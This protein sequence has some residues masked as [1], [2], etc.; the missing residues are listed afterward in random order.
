MNFILDTDHLSIVQQRRGPAFIR[1]SIRLAKVDRTEIGV[2]IISFQEQMKGWL[3]LLNRARASAQIVM[4]FGELARMA[5]SFCKMNV[6]SYTDSA[7]DQF[8][9]LRR[10]R[11]R[12][13]TTDL[14]LACVC[15]VTGATLLTRNI[16]DFRQ[17]PGLQVEDWTI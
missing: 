14:R 11:I 4:A 9:A 10:Q 1:L 3:A 6:V 8:V 7:E 12:I 15:I 2:T 5:R 13:G 16:R 17:V